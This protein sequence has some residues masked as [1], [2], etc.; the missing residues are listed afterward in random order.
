MITRLL[1]LPAFALG[2]AT[3]LLLPPENVRAFSTIGGSLDENQRDVRVFDNFLDPTANDNVTPHP[4]FPGYVGAEMAVWKAVVE[5][6]SDPHGDGTG[7]PYQPVL[8]SGDANFDAFWAGNATGIGTTNDNIV[9]ATLT[10]GAGVLA[11]TETPISN[12]W[13]IRFCEDF[14]WNDGPGAPGPHEDIQS[15]MTHEYGHALGLGHSDVGNATMQPAIGPGNVSCR[16][17]EPD[18]IAGVQFIYGAEVASKPDIIATVADAIA[19]TLTIHGTDFDASSND[20]WFASLA[21]T[22][23]P[24]DPRV[25]VLGVASTHNGK[26]IAVAIPAEAG[27]GDVIV[28]IPGETI[29]NAF[30]TDLVGTL[31]DPPVDYDHK[32]PW[33]ETLGSGEAQGPLTAFFLAEVTPATLEALQPGTDQTVTLR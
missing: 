28:K 17:L 4:Q 30:P 26:R 24:D 31:G 10:C 19:G 5:W 14:S 3:F 18:D 2:A 13:R 27:P 9:S 25:R 22:D 7:D 29:S 23:P 6:G 21:P 1:V 12:G 15:V 33:D 8:G 20:V 11:F 16:S 32:L